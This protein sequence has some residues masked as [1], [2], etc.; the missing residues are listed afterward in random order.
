M[1][2]IIFIK[3]LFFQF[4]SI[5]K[6]I[7]L[8]TWYIF[9]NF[10]IIMESALA[11]GLFVGGNVMNNDE[12][13]EKILENNVKIN[14]NYIDRFNSNEIEKNRI[15]IFRLNEDNYVNSIKRNTNFIN[16]IWREQN[17]EDKEFIIKEMLENN[18]NKRM[19]E[20]NE[21][22]KMLINDENK[23]VNNNV[24]FKI[25]YYLLF[26]IILLIIIYFFL[27]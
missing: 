22:E 16:K 19:V 10:E 8:K 7:I 17:L 2:I 26:L 1:L 5:H 4:L 13:K 9:L 6:I 18:K 23:I 11:F 3:I 14:R 20:K 24:N 12:I 25:F 21:N 27:I 15:I